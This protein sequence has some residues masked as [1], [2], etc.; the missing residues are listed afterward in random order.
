MGTY[1]KGHQMRFS[2]A[3]TYA[4]HSLVILAEGTSSEPVSS[5]RLA[6]IANM[7]ERFLLQI[8]KRLV[9][10][11][12]LDSSRGATGGYQLKRDCKDVSLLE[13]IEAIDGPLCSVSDVSTPGHQ[14]LGERM[15]KIQ[16][17]EN[18]KLASDLEKIKISALV[19]HPDKPLY[20]DIGQDEEA[21]T[22]NGEKYTEEP[23]ELSPAN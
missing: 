1:R 9:A 18:Q 15:V 4:V 5:R 22:G 16:F 20:F 23:S 14:W 19:G 3:V 21:E 8:L 7:P 17:E 10:S 11:Q 12:V 2:R 6:R 13:I